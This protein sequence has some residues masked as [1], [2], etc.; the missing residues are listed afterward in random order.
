MRG[1]PRRGLVPQEQHDMVVKGYLNGDTI[2][3]LAEF[4][5]VTSYTIKEILDD[6]NVKARPKG[7]VPKK[8]RPPMAVAKSPRPEES[9]V[10]E[11]V[12]ES[13]E[14]RSLDYILT[15]PRR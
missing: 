6:N 9:P 1:R 12:Q 7:R 5:D 2:A 4:F 8:K 15:A 14:D 10:K 11:S 13:E 3:Q